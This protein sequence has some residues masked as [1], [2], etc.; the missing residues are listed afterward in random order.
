MKKLLPV[1]SLLYLLLWMPCTIHADDSSDPEYER[2][3]QWREQMEDTQN[4]QP[5][6]TL[7]QD[8]IVDNAAL[9]SYEV[10]DEMVDVTI[11]TNGYHIYIKGST[12]FKQVHIL[13]SQDVLIMME[14]HS[15]LML[16]DGSDIINTKG[17]AVQMKSGSS[18]QE[19]NF[20]NSCRI[21]GDTA[22]AFEGMVSL[23][24]IWVE[25]TY[26]VKGTGTLSASLLY[27]DGITQAS[28]IHSTMSWF[29]ELQAASIDRMPL[30]LSTNYDETPEAEP[31]YINVITGTDIAAKVLPYV[32]ISLYINDGS[33]TISL[34]TGL[35]LQN[36]QLTLKHPDWLQNI[37]DQNQAA[38][39]ADFQQPD[40]QITSAQQFTASLSIEP[41]GGYYPYLNFPSL[42]GSNR[43]ELLYSQDNIH[44]E[45]ITYTGYDLLDSSANSDARITRIAGP[46]LKKGETYYFAYKI[47]GGM[48][49]G[50][51]CQPLKLTISNAMLEIPYD[52]PAILPTEELPK[53]DDIVTEPQLPP[54]N[55]SLKDPD[56]IVGNEGQGGGREESGYQPVTNNES[57]KGQSNA[58]N[59]AAKKTAVRKKKKHTT[60]AKGTNTASTQ[61][62][63]P[64][65][66]D[67]TRPICYG[68][69]LFTSFLFGKRIYRKR[70]QAI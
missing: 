35:Q 27:A 55:S 42:Y 54:D 5:V 45:T 10:H 48:Y 8:M 18:L 13:G 53:G 30:M 7:Q 28:D 64:L 38:Y 29:K 24:D 61:E 12:R 66:A 15:D 36:G 11:Q 1:L 6:Y 43:L 57:V 44:W 32:H 67:Q 70:K 9:W 59:T 50:Y 60:S 2:Y 17:T 19:W 26:A 21:R 51:T 34:D 56:P 41:R 39:I 20:S 65:T 58:D 52:M 3:L 4:Q 62:P 68:F 40:L 25:G 14:E 23:S 31:V 46:D 69:L 49:D 37:L 63:V 33:T 16:E 22:I 47:Y